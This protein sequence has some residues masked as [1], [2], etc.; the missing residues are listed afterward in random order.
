MRTFLPFLFGCF[1]CCPA[2][3]QTAALSAPVLDDVSHLVIDRWHYED[4]PRQRTYLDFE[5]IGVHL[6]SITVT[7]ATG[8]VMWT[9]DLSTLPVD[10]IYEV[11]YSTY[12]KGEYT[13]TLNSLTGQLTRTITVE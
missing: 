5:A 7:S 9:D 11:D 6:E 4:A 10:V 1:L 13:L 12:P 8:E 2:F 3:A